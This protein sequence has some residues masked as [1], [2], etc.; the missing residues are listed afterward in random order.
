MRSTCWLVRL[1]LLIELCTG[2]HLV[3]Q[4]TF[5]ISGTIVTSRGIVDNA[6]MIVVHGKI[7]DIRANRSAPPEMISVKVDG[8]VFP[9][10]I[11]LHNH[12]VWNV[13]PRWKL[14][15]PVTTRYEWQAMPEYTA[16]LGGPESV[17]IDKGAGCDM[18]RYAEVKALLG[19]ATSVAGSFGPTDSDPARND[20]VRGLARNLDA[21]SG[22][23]SKSLNGE[24]LR[25]V[26]F[27]FE[28]PWQQVQAIRDK[29]DSGDLKS[30]IF[31]VG[32][33]KDASAKHEFNMLK[34]QGFLRPGVIVVH[35]VALGKLEFLA[36]AANGVGFVWSPR[37]NFELYG[38]T[39]DIESAQ[40]SQVTMSLAPDWSPTGSSGILDELRFAYKWK[41]TQRA[42]RL[43][44]A[45]FLRMVT[46]NPAKLAGVGDKVGG[47]APG[48]MAD[49]IVLPRKGKAV[50]PLLSLVDSEPA[51]I[52][53]V[54][55]G[56]RPLL[57]SPDYMGQLR[58]GKHLELLTICK[59]QKALDIL[60]DT[61]GNSFADI[62]KRLEQ[63]L[64]SLGTS[65][66]PLSEC[67]K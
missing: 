47:L 21:F 56:G 30:V 52:Q 49:F 22:L 50:D 12:L 4:D 25:Y 59:Q 27:P 51:S 64:K 33:G 40:A 57:G 45:E 13:F 37:S 46:I 62:E 43:S 58:P 53:L 1:L 41:L 44:N 34:A 55:V 35:G 48:M 54:V 2:S 19:G 23:Y 66:A 67:E 14:P 31:H 32:E 3:A 18:E 15:E 11:D 17:M 29:L 39:A 26:V 8:I 36:M 63:T 38:K 24:P 61:K 28:I 5:A 42:L 60:E 10:L 20:C 16:R 65:L 6:T 9:G 7:Q